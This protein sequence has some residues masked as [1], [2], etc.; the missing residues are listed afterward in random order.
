MI[1]DSVIDAFNAR[2]V[3]LTKIEKFGPEARAKV[4]RE[5]EKAEAL[6]KNPDFAQ[7]VYQCKFELA[8]K[9][10]DIQGYTEEHETRRLAI[11]HQIA[12]IQELVDMLTRAV[13]YK[14]RVVRLEQSPPDNTQK[15][16]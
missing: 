13:Y 6:L 4:K 2:L 7:F 15:G 14:N 16:E 9:L 11:T 8:D 3:D 10:L 5:G 1:N 12:G